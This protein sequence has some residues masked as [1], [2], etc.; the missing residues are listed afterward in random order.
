MKAI[1]FLRPLGLTA[2]GLFVSARSVLAAPSD[3]V[4]STDC[5]SNTNC[6][7]DIRN[8]V[9]V[10]I[11]YLLTFIGLIAVILVIFA[12]FQMMTAQGDQGKVQKA[13]KLITYVAIGIVVMLI[14][15]AIVNFIVNIAF[16]T[17]V[18]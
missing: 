2:V 10:V 5:P 18:G 8:Q 14:A 11:N 17:P 3:I 12:G 15:Y 4:R 6:N 9:T 7:P 16:G 13:Q 1:R